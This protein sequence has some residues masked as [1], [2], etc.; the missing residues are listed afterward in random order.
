MGTNRVRTGFMGTGSRGCLA[1]LSR[2]SRGA[3]L[4]AM[5]EGSRAQSQGHHRESTGQ[6]SEFARET[7]GQCLDYAMT[8][9]GQ[10]Q[11]RCDNARAMRGF[12]QE[13]ARKLGIMLGQ[14]QEL[15]WLMLGNAVNLRGRCQD[16]V[17][18][19]PG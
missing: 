13:H 11:I 6:C 7:P 18:I 10:F 14:C 3:F 19:M 5:A 1:P 8:M 17:R 4:A 15:A 2:H 9:R 12:C 16:N